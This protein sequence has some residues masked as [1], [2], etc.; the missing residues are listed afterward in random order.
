M[1]RMWWE[2]GTGCTGSFFFRERRALERAACSQGGDGSRARLSP[3]ATSAGMAQDHPMSAMAHQ[4]QLTLLF[5][6]L[7]QRSP[8]KELVAAARRKRRVTW[9]K[10]NGLA[11]EARTAKVGSLW[12]HKQGSC[13]NSWRKI[14][15]ENF[16]RCCTGP[17]NP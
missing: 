14:L 15:E 5:F 4:M 3:R 16:Y 7:D 6:A 2:G 12:I 13:T 17:V 1:K 8:R 11:R 9:M 10:T